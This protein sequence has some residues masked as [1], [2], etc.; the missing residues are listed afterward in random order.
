[1]CNIDY[2][3]KQADISA[4]RVPLMG[5]HVKQIY[6]APRTLQGKLRGRCRFRQPEGIG[7]GGR[8]IWTP[9]DA[10]GEYLQYIFDCA[11]QPNY[12]GGVFWQRPTIERLTPVS[13]YIA[14]GNGN[15]GLSAPCKT[16]ADLPKGHESQ[17]MLDWGL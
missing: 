5:C 1:M 15:S 8:I 12:E 7:F 6:A 4:G 13:G 10:S 14:K 3:R 2:N 9:G 17:N 16:S 11:T